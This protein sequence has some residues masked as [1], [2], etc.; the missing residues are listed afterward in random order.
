[1]DAKHE[2]IRRVRIFVYES[3]EA[4]TWRDGKTLAELI[5]EAVDRYTEEEPPDPRHALRATFGALRD[6]EIPDRS[7]WDR[8]VG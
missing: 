6:L 4:P 5:R 7:E 8:R 2:W 3:H 1:V